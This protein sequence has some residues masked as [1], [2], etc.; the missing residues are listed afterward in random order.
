MDVRASAQKTYLSMLQVVPQ[1]IGILLLVS[2]LLTVIP[3]EWYGT[4]FSGHPVADPVAGAA[5][6]SIAAGNP[7]T[8]YVIGGEL[9]NT[10]ISLTA[11]TAFIVAWVTIGAIHLPM[12]MNILGKRFA[13]A[14][15]LSGFIFAILIAALTEETLSV[16]GGLL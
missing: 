1:V 4:V 2:L 7:I 8:S 11:V 12:E 15:N 3:H 13:I 16:L 5:I 10:G 9:L 6:G 14:R